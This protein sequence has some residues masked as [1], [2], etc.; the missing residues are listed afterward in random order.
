MKLKKN[1]RKKLVNTNAKVL[2][3]NKLKAI[4][5]ILEEMNISIQLL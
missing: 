1:Y 4:I 5:N 3:E 2:F